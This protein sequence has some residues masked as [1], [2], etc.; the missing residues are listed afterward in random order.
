MNRQETSAVVFLEGNKRARQSQINRST[1]T[2]WDTHTP[3]NSFTSCVCW[4]D[5]LYSSVFSIPGSLVTPLGIQLCHEKGNLKDVLQM[6]KLPVFL[7][8]LSPVSLSLKGKKTTSR[9]SSLTFD[10]NH[11]MLNTEVV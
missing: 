1:L 11:L 5:G 3:L 4:S 9:T 10:L 2:V 6:D 8:S 7:L